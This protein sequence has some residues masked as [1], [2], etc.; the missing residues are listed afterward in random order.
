MNTAT[1]AVND[2]RACYV[3]TFSL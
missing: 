3:F 2:E 1:T